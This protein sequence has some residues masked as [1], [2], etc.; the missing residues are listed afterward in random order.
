MVVAACANCIN[1]S[2]NVIPRLQI[3]IHDAEAKYG[4]LFKTFL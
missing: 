3:F 2:D 1:I 4:I